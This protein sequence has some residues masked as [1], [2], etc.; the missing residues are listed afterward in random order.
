MSTILI[1]IKLLSAIYQ[2]K[3]LPELFKNNNLEY[4]CDKTLIDEIVYLYKHA[5]KTSKTNGLLPQDQ[6]TEKTLVS[7]IEWCLSQDDNENIIKSMLIQRLYDVI[8]DNPDL[9]LVIEAGLEDINDIVLVQRNI[10]QHLSEVKNEFQEREFNK[11]LKNKLRPLLYDNSS[12]DI[13][14]ANLAEIIDLINTKM[15]SKIDEDKDK[16]I[17]E[18]I[19]TN[20]KESMLDI[21]KRS[22][23]E[24]SAT[25]TLKCGYQG[26]NDSLPNKGFTLGKTYAFFAL[27]NRGKSLILGDLTASFGLY[28]NGKDF[29]RDKTKIPTILLESA[30]D[31][32]D[33]IIR[34]LYNTITI[35]TIKEKH[36]F[37]EVNDN[38]II[39][40]ISN[41][42][43]KNNWCLIINMVDATKD[44]HAEY[45]IRRRKLMMKGHEIKVDVYDYLAMMSLKGIPGDTKSDKLQELFRVNRIYHAS[46]GALN[47]TAGQLSPAAKQLL[48]EGDSEAE[49]EFAKQIAGKSLTD[50]STKIYNELDGEYVVHV[51][52][53]PDTDNVYFCAAL[54]KLRW[55][56]EGVPN[57]KRDFI[58]K[59]DKEF[60]LI[61]DINTKAMYMKSVHHKPEGEGGEYDFV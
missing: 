37:E 19:D 41:A 6:I 9:R 59:F 18:S 22:K 32:L 29:L 48:R 7:V 28:N 26:F 40:T 44:N 45:V 47:I 3:K 24:N 25:G 43:A 30:E 8:K 53:P 61:H 54:G 12:E 16:T 2:I 10:Y 42:F 55:S 60:G 33:I 1:L 13:P 38:K 5:I 46:I 14:I 34:K 31:T 39:E 27:S 17:I 20:N 57:S 36:V 50:G 52:K 49:Y 35:N 21:I 51:A 58:Y 23:K 56:D 11:T 15:V 4:S